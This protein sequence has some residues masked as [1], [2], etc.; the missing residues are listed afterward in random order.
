MAGCKKGGDQN[1][2]ICIEKETSRDVNVRKSKKQ[3][4]FGRKRKQQVVQFHREM[5]Q[6]FDCLRE[7]GVKLSMSYLRM[8]ASDLI[9]TSLVDHDIGEG[10]FYHTKFCDPKIGMLIR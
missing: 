4:G 5:L 7:T 6:E 9:K 2:E 3:E 10:R 8:L 1:N